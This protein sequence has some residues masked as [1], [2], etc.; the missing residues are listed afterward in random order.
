[1]NINNVNTDRFK[2]LNT[3]FTHVRLSTST[4]F[5]FCLAEYTV[6]ETKKALRADAQRKETVAD[7]NILIS[8][9][10]N[11]K[12]TQKTEMGGSRKP[13]EEEWCN[14]RYQRSVITVGAVRD[15]E[16]VSSMCSS[17]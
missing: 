5:C 14:Y 7:E 1:M 4:M 9:T 6:H 3:R 16:D 15:N 2:N 8:E 13:Q 12:R 10:K 17:L 11:N